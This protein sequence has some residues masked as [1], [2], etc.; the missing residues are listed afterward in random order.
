MDECNKEAGAKPTNLLGPVEIFYSY[1]HKDEDFRKELE[2]HLSL[3][4][5][6]GEI[7]GWHDRD[8]SA[9][10]DW[11]DS[12][13]KHLESAQ[14]ILLLVSADFLASDYCYEIEMTRAMERHVEG[15][16]RVIPVILRNCD[17]SSAPFGSLQALPKDAKP[18]KSW[19]DP[20][21]A[22]KDVAAGIRKAVAQITGVPLT[23]LSSGGSTVTGLLTKK[24]SPLLGV[25][26]ILLVMVAIV[27]FSIHNRSQTITLG[28]PPVTSTPVVSPTDAPALSGIVLDGDNNPIPSAKVT[29]DQMLGMEAVE[30]SSDGLFRI[31]DIP[32]EYGETVRIRVVKEGYQPN[33][34]TEDVVLGKTPPRVR[35]RR[36]K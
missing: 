22:Y 26:C 4:R 13:D 9:G 7:A 6:S 19:A 12:I 28:S 18:I 34:Y 21:E 5:R 35:L 14:I 30:T 29:I 10:T 3:M 27:Y 11:K 36:K 20:D 2:K 16:A 32:G 8:I 31:K 24:P 15:K 17:W 33:P 23:K 1:A 25:I